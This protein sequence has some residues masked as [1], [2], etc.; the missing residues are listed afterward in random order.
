MVITG[1]SLLKFVVG[2]RMSN[3]DPNNFYVV[4]PFPGAVVGDMKDFIKPLAR[5]QPDKMII[6]VGTNDLKSLAPQ[7]IAGSIVELVNQVKQVSPSTVVGVSSLIMRKDSQAL[8]AKGRQVNSILKESCN[9]HKVHFL[10]NSNINVS[11]LNSLG[12]HLNRR[13][14]MTLQ[15]N[16]ANFANKISH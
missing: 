7:Q 6:H 15:E 5:K 9:R 8:S 13:G 11:H 3:E 1:D 16:L 10:D 2:Q 14:S 12:L 4:K